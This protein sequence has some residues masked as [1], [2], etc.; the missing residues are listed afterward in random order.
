VADDA[1]YVD[2]GFMGS[3]DLPTPHLDQLAQQGTV[4]TDAHVSAS[5]C[6]P[7]RA[8]LLMGK[9]QQ[10]TGFEA[11]IADHNQ[12][13]PEGELTIGDSFK[14]HGYKTIAI[15]KWHLGVEDQ[16]HPN[17]RGFDEFYGFLAGARSYF[18][19]EEPDTA[20]MMQQNGERVVFDGYLTDVLGQRSVDYVEENKD[21]PFF[22]YLAYNAVHTPM[23]AKP[24][25]LERFKGHD[26]QTLAAMTWSLDENVGK[27][28]AKLEAL[29]LMENTL[30][31]FINDNGGA[32]NNQSDNG[33]LKGFK[34][35]KFEA[36][37]RVPFIVTWKNTLPAD[38]DYSG[39]SSSLDIF[40]TAMAAAGIPLTD[41]PDLDGVNLIPYL[42][43]EKK[44]SPHTALFWRKLDLSG[45]RVGQDKLVRLKGY[46]DRHYDLAN[47]L[48][49]TTD[50]RESEPEQYQQLTREFAEWE[51]QLVEPK[52]REPGW[53]VVTNH[54]Q[55]SLMEN[56]QPKYTSPD[57]R[58]KYL[59]ASQLKT[60]KAD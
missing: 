58:K 22:M 44:A 6:A 35:N 19:M 32:N 17:E 20:H 2:F 14:S 28:T 57:A 4:F 24:K 45:A 1:G 40:P 16:Y 29:G 3:T 39:L 33:L 36:G 46:G 54:I 31:F 41:K 56:S 47:D 38:Q 59:K 48:G 53:E 25:D 11:N 7:S 10:K 12:G 9:Y 8:G 30:I 18:P 51:A 34:G 43:G 5:V 21:S 27:L 50:V 15:G 26:R 42:T 60:G 49:E 23:H 52:W 55:Q 13:L 37:H